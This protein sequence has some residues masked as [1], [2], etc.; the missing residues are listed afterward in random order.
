MAGGFNSSLSKDDILE[1]ER[2][3]KQVFK[4]EASR[5]AAM[6]REKAKGRTS[7]TSR[8]SMGRGWLR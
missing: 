4:A 3:E 6:A 5:A 2:R 8:S 7:G 1:I